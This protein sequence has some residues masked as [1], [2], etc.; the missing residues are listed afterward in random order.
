MTEWLNDWVTACSV[1]FLLKF[2]F[3]L[4]LQETEVTF[5]HMPRGLSVGKPQRSQ[6]TFLPSLLSTLYLTPLYSLFTHTSLPTHCTRKRGHLRTHATRANSWETT[7]VSINLPS[8][9]SFNYIL[10][11]P[12]LPF[13]SNFPFYSFYEKLESPSLTRREG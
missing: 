1:L 6:W 2:L 11:S 10:K 5:A 8:Y 13:Y 12:L 7:V 9:T 3:L 4:I